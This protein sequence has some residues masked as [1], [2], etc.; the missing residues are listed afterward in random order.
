MSCLVRAA[1]MFRLEAN[2]QS[3]RNELSLAPKICL[4]PGGLSNGK[5]MGN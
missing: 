3:A 1:W 2:F 4:P 5:A